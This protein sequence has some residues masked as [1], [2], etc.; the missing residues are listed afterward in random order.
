MG[1]MKFQLLPYIIPCYP[2]Y[3]LL[4]NLYES[5]PSIFLSP[6]LLITLPVGVIT[7]IDINQNKSIQ[8]QKQLV[9]IDMF[10]H[11]YGQAFLQGVPCSINNRDSKTV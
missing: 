8:F 1:M 5:V 3:K 11:F 4:L 10:I 7:A 2:K 6:N 9:F